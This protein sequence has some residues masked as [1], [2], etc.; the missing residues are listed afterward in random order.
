MAITSADPDNNPATPRPSISFGPASGGGSR[1][2]RAEFPA[3]TG[4]SSLSEYYRGGGVVPTS[5]IVAGEIS[6]EYGSNQLIESRYAT[7]TGGSGTLSEINNSAPEYLFY[8]RKVKSSSAPDVISSIPYSEGVNN[9][10]VNF[11][12][13]TSQARIRIYYNG[14]EVYTSALMNASTAI[15]TTEQS[16]L[17]NGSTIKTRLNTSIKSLAW[18]HWNLAGNIPLSG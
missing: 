1:S 3:D 8:V 5:S 2:L 18:F 15:N 17:V 12:P 13:G 16:V 6:S 11:T 9:W 4:S 7:I 14:V 10:R